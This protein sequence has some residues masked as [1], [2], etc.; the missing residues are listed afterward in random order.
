MRCFII[1]YICFRSV[2]KMSSLS[3]Y[4]KV[5]HRPV[6]SLKPNEIHLHCHPIL[7]D[8][9]WQADSLQVL[10]TMPT[11]PNH[12]FYQFDR[13]ILYLFCL[14]M[15]F[16]LYL[17]YASRKLPIFSYFV[18]CTC[19]FISMF[20]KLIL[21]LSCTFFVRLSIIFRPNR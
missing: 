6:G 9:I 11:S 15:I 8:P 2:Y 14:L 20:I 21:R 5:S 3:L 10:T 18:D 7:V 12:Y 13:N 19:Q 4:S 1:I 16:L 17:I